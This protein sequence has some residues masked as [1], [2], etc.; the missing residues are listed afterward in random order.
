MKILAVDIGT[1]TQDILLLDTRLDVEN[2]L[3][4]VMP[5]PTMMARR[6]LQAATQRGEAVVLTGVTMG[7]G[8]SHWAAEDHLEAGLRLY[9]TPDAARSFNDDLEM[10]REMGIT[11]IG[12]DEA[13]GLPEDVVRLELR[14][15][16]LGAIL[17]AFASFGV[18]LSD[19]DAVAAAVFDHGAA[20]PGVSDRKFRFDHIAERVAARPALG[21]FAFLAEDVP[22]IM[23]RMQAVVAAAGNVDAPLVLMDTAPAAVL[24]A[25][26]DPEARTRAR[27]LVANLGNLHTLAF[28]RGP[29]D[30]AEGTFEHHTGLLSAQKLEGLLR[31]LAAGTLDHEAVYRDHGHGAYIPDPT[32]LPLPNG[33][34]SVVVTGPRRAML[35]GSSLRPA[36]AT[37][38]GDMMLAG[39]FGLLAA[40]ADVLPA[41]AEPIRASLY[42][43]DHGAPPWEL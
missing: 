30:V 36:F 26:L 43:T 1:G 40:T 18:G 41:L 3:K 13:A 8:P 25:T 37:P 5:S 2:S 10:I 21:S 6:K 33:Q 15:L 16:D 32:P 23:T 38:Y 35:A 4:M 29:G 22:A 14:D 11:V 20:P 34:S 7:G 24:G 27:R 39:C 17:V 9:A 42:G 28:R 31:E 12:E 19:V